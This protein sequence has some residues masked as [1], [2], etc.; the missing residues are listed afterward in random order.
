M[1]AAAET[2]ITTK[3]NTTKDDLSEVNDVNFGQI[4]DN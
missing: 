2:K 3:D 4:K 1:S